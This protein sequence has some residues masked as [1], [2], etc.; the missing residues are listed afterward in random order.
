MKYYLVKC[1][2]GHVGR[3]KYLPLNVPIEAKSIKEASLKAKAIRGIKRHHKNWCL[4]KPKEIS[5]D[6]YLIALEKFKNDRY[7]ECKTR[8]R[9][10]LFEDRLLDEE[11]YIRVDKIKTN[12][13]KFR[14]KKIR[15]IESVK[16]KQK[17]LQIMIDSLNDEMKYF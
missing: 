1:K 7:F 12:H 5:Y 15:N 6:K 9:T 3:D 17:K 10:E 8:S 4:E 14:N 2:F 16:F 13:K 11:T